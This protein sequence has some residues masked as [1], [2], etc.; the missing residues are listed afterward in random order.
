VTGQQKNHSRISKEKGRVNDSKQ[1]KTSGLL[2][3][4]INLKIQLGFKP[5]FDISE[6]I[7][8]RFMYHSK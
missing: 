4:S 2:L 1:T 8:S 7:F 6:N 3:L 5:F